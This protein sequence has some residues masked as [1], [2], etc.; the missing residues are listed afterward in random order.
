[1]KYYYATG[2]NLNA[3]PLYLFNENRTDVRMCA[4]LIDSLKNHQDP[5][6]PQFA[7]PIGDTVEYNGVTYVPGDFVGAPPGEDLE[8]FSM[9]GPGIASSGTPTP[10]ITATE[11]HFM[12]AECLVATGNPGGARA[13]YKE[14]LRVSL[15]EYG[16]FNQ[17][18]YDAYSSAIDLIPDPLLLRAIMTEKWI[19]LTYNTEVFNDW[20]RTGFP[21]LTPNPNGEIDEVPR[22]FPY[23]VAPITYNAANVPDLGAEPL[24]VRVWWDQ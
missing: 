22:R 19:S 10:I 15:E 1:M 5:R 21:V 2:N 7:E 24:T 17:V 14:A 16:V 9:P 23:A 20:R 4:T 11:V 6:L 8:F 3:N 12:R 18:W 13:A